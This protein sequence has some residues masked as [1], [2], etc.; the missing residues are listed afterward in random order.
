MRRIAKSE[1]SSTEQDVAMIEKLESL[2]HAL[3][4]AEEENRS[5]NDAFYKESGFQIKRKKSLIEDAGSGV[6]VTEGCISES[7]IAAMYPGRDDLGFHLQFQHLN[8][9]KYCTTW[10]KW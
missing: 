1:D 3:W 8:S 6:F 7:T 4:V 2:F 10:S 9:H 5:T